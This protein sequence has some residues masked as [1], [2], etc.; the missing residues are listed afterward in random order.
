M[1][2]R[3]FWSSQL[4]NQNF[5]LS[6]WTP[7]PYKSSLPQYKLTAKKGYESTHSLIKYRLGT[8]ITPDTVLDARDIVRNKTKSLLSQGKKDNEYATNMTSWKMLEKE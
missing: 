1:L 7:P 8:Y 5:T 4:Q 3:A 6:C 2:K